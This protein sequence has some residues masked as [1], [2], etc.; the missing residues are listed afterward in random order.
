MNEA[1]SWS[2]R[3]LD[4]RLL[5]S[6]AASDQ[7]LGRWNEVISFPDFRSGS[8]TRN[9]ATIR[10]KFAALWITLAL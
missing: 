8:E 5:L 4:P 6:S 9:E 2:L 1:S 7:K 3:S 10:V